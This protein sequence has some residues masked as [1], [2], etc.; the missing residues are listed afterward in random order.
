MLD[1]LNTFDDAV[2]TGRETQHRCTVAT[3]SGLLFRSQDR[4]ADLMKFF[5][6]E[7]ARIARKRRIGRRRGLISV[8][9]GS[10]KLGRGTRAWGETETRLKT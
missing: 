1:L 10:L 3:A 5:R 4:S 2:D 6:A 9:K 7:L 8:C